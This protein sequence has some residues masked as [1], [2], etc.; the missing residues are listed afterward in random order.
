MSEFDVVLVGATG[1]V[2]RLT[3]AA[4]AESA[5]ASTRIALA[6]RD[7]RSVAAV[8]DGFGERAA[9]WGVIRVDVTDDDSVRALT[10]RCRVVLSTA[11]PYHRLGLPLVRACADAGTHYADLTGEVAF[12]RRSI[13]Q[14]DAPARRSG[15]KIVHSCGFDSIPSDLGVM[16]AAQA[17]A[18]EEAGALTDVFGVVASMRGGFSGGTID[19]LR[20]QI[21]AT[22]RNAA[23][24]RLVADPYGLSP[25][26]G[27]EPDLGPQPDIFVP[28]REPRLGRRWVAPF[29]MAPY[30]TR[31]VRRSN[32]LTGFAYGRGMRYREGVSTGARPRDAAVAAAATIGTVAGY[33]G[34]ASRLT[35][36][37]ADRL[38]PSPG[39]G[40]GE[41]VLNSGHFTFETTAWTASGQRIRSSV[42]AGLDPGYGATSVMLAQA[43][44][45]LAH[46]DFDDAHAGGG[47]LT[48]ATALGDSLVRRL[49]G[50]GFVLT[51]TPG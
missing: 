39:E 33:A 7:E 31:V 18:T 4:L 29:V 19:S 10:D 41:D 20:V 42:G 22:R 21:D 35:R 15:A 32:A 51:S 50:Q 48:P 8:R 46:D 3:A 9:Q 43:G 37:L 34:L 2:G 25:D 27:A 13:E 1:F 28:Y 24:A 49:D 23:T 5:P 30:N 45:S 12:A 47:V 44:L 16:L 36:R 38:L 17:A 6:G 14:C 40:P 26:R 11:G